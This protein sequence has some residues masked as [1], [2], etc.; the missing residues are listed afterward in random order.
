MSQFI[1]LFTTFVADDMYY[2]S[3]TYAINRQ[4]NDLF[5]KHIF[6]YNNI[7]VCMVLSM[8]NVQTYTVYDN[9]LIYNME[10]KSK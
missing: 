8:I 4:Y 10:H 5:P 6:M 3:I 2:G 7:V 1:N 9:T